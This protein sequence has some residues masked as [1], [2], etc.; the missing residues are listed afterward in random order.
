MAIVCC[1]FGS[2]C[3]VKM[4]HYTFRLHVE[5]ILIIQFAGLFEEC[6][7][8]AVEAINAQQD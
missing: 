1:G 3:R 5:L 4:S 6:L 2:R 8:Q 7:T